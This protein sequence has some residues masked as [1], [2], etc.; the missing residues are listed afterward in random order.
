MS[1]S[2]SKPEPKMF[3][4]SRPHAWH[5]SIALWMRWMAIGIRRARKRSPCG[6]DGEAADNHPFHHVQRIA[7]QHAAV[8]ERARV[9]LVGV[10]DEV[11]GLL[12][13]PP[14]PSS[15]FARWDIRRRR[16]RGAS[17]AVIFVDHPL[18]IALVQHLG[19]GLEAAVVE[20]FLDALGIDHAVVPQGHAALAVE[21][22]HVA[23]K[24]QKLAADG[25]A[26]TFKCSTG[27]P[28]SE[29]S[30]MISSSSA[31]SLTR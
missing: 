29:C 28:P 19:Q 8:H 15:I 4:P 23:V 21:E 20:I 26:G 14:R 5:C 27:R 6:A 9:A 1:R 12:R 18:R 2:K 7:F 16:G 22:G 30:R 11:A 24:L 3:L 13:P 31:S 25:F 17:S 10:A